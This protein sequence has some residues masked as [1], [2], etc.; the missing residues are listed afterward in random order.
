MERIILH[1]DMNSYF[2][3]VEQQARPALRGKPIAVTG[4]DK[5]RTIIVA[6][7][8][9]AKRLGIKTGMR[10]R[11]AKVIFRNVVVLAPDPDKYRFVN[12]A[13]LKLLA[14]YS[15]NVSV[16]SIDEMVMSL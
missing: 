1:I 4:S 2:A 10:V 14:S 12:R 5:K 11:E 7:S 6:A 16:E 3:S 9:E 8:V 13:L 15:S